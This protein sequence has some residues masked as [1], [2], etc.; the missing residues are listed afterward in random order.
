MSEIDEQ[1]ENNNKH[2]EEL[3]Q[4]LSQTYTL[5]EALIEAI[6]NWL[7]TSRKASRQMEHDIIEL[8]LGILYNCNSIL[9]LVKV[10]PCTCDTKQDTVKPKDVMYN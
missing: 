1:I 6:T 10:K 3:R 9:N 2:I 7:P 8:S 5:K 4:K